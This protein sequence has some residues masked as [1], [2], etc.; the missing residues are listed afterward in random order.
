MRCAPP[1]G[2]LRRL[3]LCAST[4]TALIL[5]AGVMPHDE[6]AIAAPLTTATAPGTRLVPSAT[7]W[8]ICLVLPVRE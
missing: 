7:P 4:L 3:P 8:A 2:R 6:V 1:V 5:L